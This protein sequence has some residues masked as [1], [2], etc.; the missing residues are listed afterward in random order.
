MLS[1]ILK[2]LTKKESSPP[3]LVKPT[4]GIITP[5]HTVFLAHLLSKAL[6]ELGFEVR[7][8][9]GEYSGDFQETY[10][11][12]IC[13]QV[14]KRLPASFIA[15]QMEQA[16][17]QWFDK[18]YLSL[19]NNPEVYVLDYSSRNLPFLISQ[20]LRPDRLQVAQLAEFSGYT[21]FLR[22]RQLLTSGETKKSYDVLFYGGINERRFKILSKIDREF[23]T[24]IAVGVFGPQLYELVTRSKL[25]V[26]IHYYD[27]SPL[28]STRIFEAISLGARVVSET[29]ADSDEYLR[30]SDRVTFAQSGDANEIIGAIRRELNPP[31]GSSFE[32]TANSAVLN[33]QAF[34]E[35]VKLASQHMRWSNS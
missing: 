28:E 8:Q 33:Y 10:F 15:F 25:V 21:D 29:S 11:I 34:F 22:H 1:K 19:L 4:I 35:A 17:T 31:G 12:V 2:S 26:N 13:A 9:L 5:H 14:F 20:G 30:L 16:G 24:K 18:G 3:A 23:S 6:G 27:D 7:I 32:N